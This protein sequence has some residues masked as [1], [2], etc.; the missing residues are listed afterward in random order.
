MKKNKLWGKELVSAALSLVLAAGLLP[1]MPATALAVAKDGS[2]SQVHVVVD[3]TVFPKSEGAAWDGT[4][5]DTWIDITDSTTMMDA[6][7]AALDEVH[8]VQEGASSGYISEINGLAQMEGGQMSGWMGTQNDWF[9]NFGFKDIDVE[10]NDD[11][12]VF[13]SKDAG[14]D[15]G[16][17]WNN[18]ITTVDAVVF[19]AGEL[20][21]AFS[22]DVE[23]YTLTLPAGTTSVM[24]TP[25]AT[26]KNFQVRTFV[27]DT[28]Y[29]RTQSV[30]VQEGTVITVKCGDPSWP[31]MN[32]SEGAHTYT[33]TVACEA[34][35]GITGEG[36]QESPYLLKNAVNLAEVSANVAA[37]EK[38]EGKY[39]KMT[40]DIELPAD[41]TPIGTSSV[42][43]KGSID[44]DNHLLTI[45]VDGLPLL[46][47]TEE[48]AVSNLNIYGEKIAGYGL[49]NIYTTG[50]QKACIT[51]KNV[52]LK[53][54]SSTLKSGFIG[55]Y[56]SGSH[57][58]TIEDCTIEEGVTIGYTGTEN[59]IG[60]FGGEYNGTVKNSVS[61][62]TVKGNNF[63]GGIIADKGQSM[64][65]FV[66][67][68]CTFDG[69]V[70]ATGNYVGGILGAGYAGTN[71][72]MASAPNAMWPTVTN[73]TM[74]GSVTGINRVGGIWGGEGAVYQCWTNGV[75]TL[76]GN[77]VAGTVSG[78][79]ET[80]AIVGFIAGL[81]KCTTIE[82]NKYVAS[83]APAGIG[84]IEWVDTSYEN[85]TAVEGTTYFNSSVSLP[86]F[87][88]GT[89]RWDPSCFTVKNL[90]R[91]DDPL[92][93]DAE[94]LVKVISSE[95]SVELSEGD[96]QL[97]KVGDT[98]TVTVTATAHAPYA[99][100][101]T[102]LAA[103]QATLDYDDSMLELVSVEK[104]AGLSESATFLPEEGAAEALFSFYGNETS[105]ANGI[106]VAKV[107]FKAIKAAD[108]VSV[109]A[110]DAIVSAAA[111]SADIEPTII[112]TDFIDVLAQAIKG[113]ANGNGRM[114]I[115]DA[116][117]VY[118]MSCGK[119][120]ES[121]ENL[122]I[123]ATWSHATLLWVAN[124][125]NDDAIDAAD[126]FAIQ[127][128]IHAG[129][130]F[131]A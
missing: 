89:G 74:S 50:S 4:L 115:V 27:G 29:K 33:F 128:A 5:V 25:T 131:A 65:T 125:N 93:A 61:H 67:D 105:A 97:V 77:V 16:G 28:Q 68:N 111:Q 64:G 82:N 20:D 94:N 36:T 92:G 7:V 109:S 24:V 120:G 79:S 75:G 87:K 76:A 118:D 106:E 130:T 19:S 37:G 72:G 58:I 83:A 123:P 6:V 18:N 9:T 126:A 71:W 49:V 12:H 42:R 46:G 34:E 38:Y 121:Y 108:H 86:D 13:Y 114:N 15:H 69:T 48:A 85:P 110:K 91:T 11:L 116:Q 39:F 26:N 21:K 66:I 80:G 84:R 40:A 104:G 78:Q 62:A 43:F 88:A 51:I 70:E 57:P 44:G 41:W 81:N 60:S 90:N 30:P 63:V 3:N 45:P 101:D 10:A 31:S 55:G 124:V 52:T 117:V 22:S 1:V 98:F 23:S 73:N 35:Q 32:P 112:P 56:A 113:D 96:T 59:N 103:L 127:H 100:M 102:S 8:A 53:S 47:A 129:T 54:G 2:K 107:T 99:G 122:P 95:Y 17:T 119:Y 14:V